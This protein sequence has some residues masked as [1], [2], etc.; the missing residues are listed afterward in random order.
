MS[1]GGVGVKVCVVD[2]YY[3][4]IDFAC[5]ARQKN[6]TVHYVD[7]TPLLGSWSPEDWEG[8]FGF[9]NEE[10]YWPQ[11]EWFVR[12]S[13]SSKNQTCGAVIHADGFPLE[14]KGPLLEHHLNTKFDSSVIN[15]I[16]NQS[17]EFK[18]LNKSWPILAAIASGSTQAEPE[19]KN[20]L[21]LFQD[22]TLRYP[23]R[24]DYQSL[25][26]RAKNH[27]VQFLN[28]NEWT[29]KLSPDFFKN[30][31]ATVCAVNSE[32]FANIYSQDAETNLAQ[33]KITPHNWS[34]IKSLYPDVCHPEWQWVRYSFLLD[35]SANTNDWPLSFTYIPTLNEPWREENFMV[36]RKSDY[37]SWWDVWLKLPYLNL[38]D[39]DFYQIHKERIIYKLDKFMPKLKVVEY[40]L[41]TQSVE[42]VKGVPFPIYSNSIRPQ[43]ISDNFYHLTEEDMPRFDID[44]R[45]KMHREL[46]E[47]LVKRSEKAKK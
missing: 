19:L 20:P 23:H 28:V 42:R 36:M 7:L 11:Q 33:S 26:D 43:K 14:F 40:R 8:P 29:E 47:T 31:E 13:F 15:F 24:Q 27:G 30:Y 9:F 45:A 25:I 46:I 5:E 35:S 34:K 38:F 22:Y 21:P 12:S 18:N 16:K 37:N 3:R 17:W 2:A 1:S 41:P 39:T 10:N 44:Y 32:T 6:F 4:A